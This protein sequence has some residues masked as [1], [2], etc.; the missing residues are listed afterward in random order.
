MTD[1]MW[2]SN[3]AAVMGGGIALLGPQDNTNESTVHY[4]NR[5]SSLT[6]SGAGS[7]NHGGSTAILV[8][9]S[10]GSSPEASPSNRT[11]A[12]NTTAATDLQRMVV[13]I[14]NNT[15]VANTAGTYGGALSLQQLVTAVVSDSSLVSNSAGIGAAVF[16]GES[17]NL[18]VKDSSNLANNSASESGGALYCAGCA[19]NILQATVSGNSGATGGGAVL[20]VENAQVGC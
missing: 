20:A 9:M 6:G 5:S 4:D 14:R 1:V 8:A 3:S 11:R 17:T 2:A 19:A 15:F 13:H 18:T 7:A 12:S 10:G 16:S